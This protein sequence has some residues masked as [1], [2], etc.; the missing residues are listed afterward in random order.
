MSDAGAAV[1]SGV[2]KLSGAEIGIA[3]AGFIALVRCT[4]Y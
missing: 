2:V 4:L 3:V 1:A